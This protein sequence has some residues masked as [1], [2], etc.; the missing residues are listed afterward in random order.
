MKPASEPRFRSL[1]RRA[2]LVVAAAG[3]LCL[4]AG[5]ASTHDTED[6]VADGGQWGNKGGRRATG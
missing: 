2:I 3:A 5:N 6:V 1:I 4:C